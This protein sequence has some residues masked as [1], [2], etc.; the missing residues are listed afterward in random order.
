M[1]PGVEPV[2]IAQGSEVTPGL[3]ERFLNGVL[4]LVGIAQDQPGSAVEPA[5]G[6]EGERVE[7]VQ[8]APV[9]STSSRR[10]T[11]SSVSCVV[12][13]RHKERRTG[14]A[15]GSPRLGRA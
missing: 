15:I 3:G 5:N 11:N 1:K 14:E 13:L 12:E 7:G 8:V 2:R 10:A 4:G 9:P 6:S